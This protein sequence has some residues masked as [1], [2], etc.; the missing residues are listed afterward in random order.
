MDAV[1]YAASASSDISTQ[2]V[3]HPPEYKSGDVIYPYKKAK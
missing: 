2:V 3:V 1:A